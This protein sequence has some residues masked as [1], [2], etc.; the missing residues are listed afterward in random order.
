MYHREQKS[1]P[2]RLFSGGWWALFTV[3]VWELVEEGFETIIAYCVSEVFAMFIV[4]AL[5][6]LAIIGTTQGIKVCIKRFLVPIVKTLIYKEGHDKMSKIKQ[7]FAWIWANKKSLLGVSSTAVA[8]FSAMRLIPAHDL[9]VIAWH[10]INV[11]NVIYYSCLG[12]LALL[13]VSGKGFESVAT[14]LERVGLIKAQKEEKAIEKE[15]KKEIVTAQKTANQTQAEQEKARTKA[16]AEAQAKAEKEKADAEHRAK[17]E[18][19]KAKLIA[20]QNKK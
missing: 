8:T 5:S 17:V 1:I 10:G 14:F 19:A 11:T 16:L 4:K 7:F 13:G 2:K 20:E 12:L 15:A 3:F 9:P 18:Q 6:T